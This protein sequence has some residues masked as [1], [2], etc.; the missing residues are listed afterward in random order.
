MPP[1]SPQ[2]VA[3]SEQQVVS[4]LNLNEDE[5]EREIWGFLINNI[6]ITRQQFVLESIE[7]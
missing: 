2:E 3:F 6:Y 4:L 7:K 5:R 1:M